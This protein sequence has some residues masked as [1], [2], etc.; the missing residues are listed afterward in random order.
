[1]AVPS[2]AAAKKPKKVNATYLAL[3]DSLAFGYSEQLLNE[4]QSKGDPASAFEHGYAND[5]LNLVNAKKQIQLV[6]DGCPGETSAS[7]IGNGPLLAAIQATDP[8]VTGEAPCAYHNTD[9]L[10]L[11]NEYGAGESQ[12]ESAVA[13]VVT[14]AA[15][16]TPVKAITL[17]IGAND[18]LHLIAK[19]EAEVKARQTKKVIGIATVEA[20]QA[21]AKHVETIALKEIEEFVIGKA[22]EQAYGETGGPEVVGLEAFEAAVGKDAA[23]YEATHAAELAGML[24]PDE[25]TYAATHGAELAAE[26]K[27]DGEYFAYVYETTHAAELTAEG[28]EVA[29]AEIE[30]D[31]PAV[32]AQIVTNA[33]ATIETLKQAGFKGKF[34]FVGTYNSYGNDYGT[35]ELLAGSN[36]LL[37]ALSAAEKKAFKKGPAKACVVDEQTLFNTETEPSET[38]HMEEWTNMA[39]FTTFEGKSNGPDIH[40]TPLGYEKMAEYIKSNCKF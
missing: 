3:G 16:G 6:N 15:K 37:A 29:K 20:E 5:Y 26:G 11:H 31:A 30:A 21:V 32:F 34:I 23:E 18:Q 7:L 17:D 8:A 27:A 4:N 1:M 36:A 33:G 22:E 9:G 12:L 40:A 14:E 38:E 2:I 19:I 10:P 28:N 39:N 35:G 25:E 13:S 24:I